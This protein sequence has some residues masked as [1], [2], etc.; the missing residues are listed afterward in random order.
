LLKIDSEVNL[1]R[2]FLNGLIKN[3]PN[4]PN[5]LIKEKVLNINNIK[6]YLFCSEQVLKDAKTDKN[7]KIP[8]MFY[9][10]GG[11]F[12]ICNTELYYSKILRY[13]ASKLKVAIISIE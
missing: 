2:S 3:R 11:G 8:V 13:F 10:H 7:G 4:P 1:L 6:A 5:E 9:Y 12:V